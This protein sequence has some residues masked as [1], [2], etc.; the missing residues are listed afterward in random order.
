MMLLR[1]KVVTKYESLHPFFL[2]GVFCNRHRKLWGQ[3]KQLQIHE[4]TQVLFELYQSLISTM[5][6]NS[7]TPDLGD[8]NCPKDWVVRNR[9]DVFTETKIQSRRDLSSSHVE[10]Q[11]LPMGRER[12]DPDINIMD[13]LQ[14]SSSETDW[15]PQP[16]I[17]RTPRTCG[18]TVL[19]M[20]LS[21]HDT[22][23]F[24]VI[25]YWRAMACR[26]DVVP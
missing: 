16:V 26:D 2:K 15:T 25:L 5:K 14:Y 8:R 18:T 6:L 12:S 11:I 9:W 13:F 10:D 19:D 3:T 24:T 23:R 17:S 20:N 22:V 4:Y 21:N 7:Y 1:S